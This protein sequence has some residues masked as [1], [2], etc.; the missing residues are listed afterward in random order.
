MPPA[1]LQLRAAALLE[2][3]RRQR[4]EAT[5]PPPKGL[6]GIPERWEDF[7]R[8][9]QIRSGKG[10]IPFNPYEYQVRLSDLMD[11]T[12]GLVVVKPRQHGL[13]EMFANK[14]LH[15]ACLYPGY[16]AAVFSKTQKDTSNIAKRV[17]LMA[18][19]A[20]IPLA[21]DSQQDIAIAGGGRIVF[22]TSTPNAGRGLES[23][24]DVLYDECAFVAG[25]DQIYAAAAPAQSLPE[26]EGVAHTILLSTPNAKQGMYYET[27]MANN[28]EHDP[29][30]TC[31]LL[32]EGEI[33]PYQEWVDEDNWGKAFIH[34]RAHPIHGQNP[35]YLENVQRKQKIPWAQVQREFNLSFD[36]STGGVLFNA[37]AVHKQAV[38][39]WAAPIPK[40]KYI[41]GIDPNFGGD[42]RFVCQVWKVGAVSSLVAEY[43]E[44]QRSVEQS[45]ARCL[46]LIDQYKPEMVV[47]EGNSGGRIVL[48]QL[49][50]ARPRIR[51]EQVVT[52]R[53]NKIVSTDRIAIA[54]EQGA[55]EYPADWAGISEMLNFGLKDRAAIQGHD[56][57]VMAWA[58]AFSF[59]DEVLASGAGWRLT[60]AY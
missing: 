21:T 8:L 38:G 17:R 5:A 37:D 27:L 4:G 54:V 60:S 49:I 50:K 9:T 48:Q 33:D 30:E 26:S 53:Q 3:R 59:L 41:I 57:R 46:D 23:V 56:D 31:R 40:Q 35:F 22:Q 24:W 42:D 10:F 6:K 51:F 29:L 52:T 1:S 28:G 36:D 45:Q 15:K 20:N 55:V 44:A 12:R 47:V 14:F 25:I 16:L 13:T 2:L 18:S 58:I 7:A 32:R 11:R 34:W 19:T 43:A 39:Q